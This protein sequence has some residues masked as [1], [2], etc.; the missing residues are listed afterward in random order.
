MS[1]LDLLILFNAVSFL[2]Y[3]GSCLA[4]DYMK[5][6]F[7]RYGLAR[8]RI[9]TGLLELAGAVGL[10]AGLMDPWIGLSA[11]VGLSLLMLLGFLVRLRIRDGLLK[12]SPALLYLFL[13]LV[14]VIGFS[15]QA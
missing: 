4:T 15:R 6:E 8:Y 13:N 9:L 7:Y 14:L 12:S 10:I 1:W 3:G 11:A 5:R 2:L